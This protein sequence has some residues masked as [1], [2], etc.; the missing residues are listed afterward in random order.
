MSSVSIVA[1]YDAPGNGPAG[2]AWDGRGLWNADFT[3]GR[4]Y[5]VD[6]GSGEVLRSLVCPGNLSG[7]AWD[8]RS[9][10]QSLHEE[11]LLRRINPETKDFDQ[12]IA[13]PGHGWLSGVAWDG[14]NLWVVS[15]Q[16]GKMLAVERESGRVIRTFS[17]PV[18]GGGLDYQDGHLWLSVAYPMAFDETYQQFEWQGEERSFAL[19]QIDARDGREVTRHEAQHL[20]MGVAWVRGEIWLAHTGARKLYRGRIEP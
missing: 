9:L 20:Y 11:G 2:L 13:L 5:A 14:R 15:Q 4:I 6:P 3:A 8:G 7:L 18:A 16:K 1:T 10:W 19:L 12:T 17:V